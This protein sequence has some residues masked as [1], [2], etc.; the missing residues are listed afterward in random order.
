MKIAF[1]SFFEEGR[2]SGP[3]Y[4]N[5]SLAKHLR[6][7]FEVELYTTKFKS[8]PFELNG[9]QIRS[10]FDFCLKPKGEYEFVFISGVFYPVY[11]L[12]G[13]L[14]RVKKYRLILSPRGNL[15]KD[16]LKHGFPK[17]QLYLR[18][19]KRTCVPFL[20]GVHFLSAEEKRNSIQ[21]PC[22]IPDIVSPNGFS[23]EYAYNKVPRRNN[24]TYVGR[25]DVH[26][27]GLD[28]FI[29]AIA[30][31]QNL[32]RSQGWS[33][34]LYGPSKGH[35]AEFLQKLI[36]EF[37]LSDLI[38]I[39]P[40]IFGKEK[41]E[42]LSSSKIFMHPSRYEGMPQSVIEA[43]V[44]GCI[45]I[46]TAKCNMAEFLPDSF[47]TYDLTAQALSEGIKKSTQLAKDNSVHDE[48]IDFARVFSWDNIALN[49]VSQL[50]RI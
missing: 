31:S 16:A 44:C 35:D 43:L 1:I 10:F 45:P 29:K 9:E 28:V 49:L 48:I 15:M 36:S 2:L 7:W 11:F 34:K 40:P 32:L 18:L 46:I 13:L 50:Q 22:N 17:K 41:I 26:H 30:L 47:G 24:I 3:S 23:G 20:A 25:L 39:L 27:K 12:M 4:S 42:I 8:D 5:T 37:S 19:F 38:K 6:S 14:S 33:V 21:L